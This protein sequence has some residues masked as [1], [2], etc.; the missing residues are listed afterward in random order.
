MQRQAGVQRVTEIA[1]KHA[2][3]L[4]VP[5]RQFTP[6]PAGQQRASPSLPPRA[7]TTTPP[8][9]LQ[10]LPL[11]YPPTLK[12]P[13]TGDLNTSLLSCVNVLEVTCWLANTCEVKKHKELPNQVPIHL[14]LSMH[15]RKKN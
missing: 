9:P 15:L 14:S 6:V 5:V 12:S 4:K 3:M 7:T 13:G 1:A 10:P 2:R 11:R 8:P